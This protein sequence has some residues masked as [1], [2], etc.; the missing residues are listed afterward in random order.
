MNRFFLLIFLILAPVFAKAE[1]TITITLINR[2]HY[3]FT[4]SA[5]QAAPGCNISIDKEILGPNQSAIIK[6]TITGNVDLKAKILFNKNVDIFSISVNR[7]KK[8]GQPYF[9]MDSSLVYTKVDKLV[10]NK[11]KIPNHLSYIGATVYLD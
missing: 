1:S 5:Y 10:F 11:D 9:N 3:Q 4:F 7:L 8:F 6:G 2:S